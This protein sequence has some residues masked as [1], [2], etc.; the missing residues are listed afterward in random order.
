MRLR[1]QVPRLDEV[2][3]GL[4]WVL[5][6]SPESGHLTMVPRLRALTVTRMPG[7]PDLAVYYSYDDQ[8]VTL[9]HILMTDP[10]QQRVQGNGD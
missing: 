2:L 7:I 10:A 1:A 4:I 9:E 8:T 3:R 6:R 5:E